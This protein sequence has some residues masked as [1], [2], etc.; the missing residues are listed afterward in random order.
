MDLGL[1]GKVTVITGGSSGIGYSTAELFAREGAR[2]VI[3]ARRPGVLKE[4]AERVAG[5][6]G[7]D[8]DHVVTDVTKVGDLDALVAHVTERYG[9][10]DILVNNAG[11]GIYKPFLDVTDEELVYGMEINFFAQFRLIQRF[12]PLMIGSGG[13]DIVNVT[14]ATGIRV[15]APP[16]R[17]SCTGPAKAAEVRLSRVLA[18]ELGEH[19]I[20]VNAIVPGLINTQERFAKWERE[21]AKTE[22]DQDAAERT[23]TEWGTGI[24]LPE[25]RWG[26][27]EEVASLIAFTAS[28][29]SGFT[30]GA[31]L[32]V[33]G[34]DDKS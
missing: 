4:A 20:R 2:V 3:A 5:Q 13:G 8:V 24:S 10:I 12:A 30:Q 33:D 9:R 7:R 21:L 25:H 27:P 19:N 1:A 15:T 23:R 32:V 34:G 22:L 11:T 6:T 31:T 26:T 14:G 18:A 16:F 29:Q 17:S 28:G